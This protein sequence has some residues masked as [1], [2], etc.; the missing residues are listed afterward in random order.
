MPIKMEDI[1]SVENELTRFTAKL[2]AASLWLTNVGTT[3]TKRGKKRIPVPNGGRDTA[4][5]KR[6][7]MDLKIELTKL[8]NPT[9]E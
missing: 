2:E 1:K 8:T 4:A 6:A 9:S 7:A 3:K 5:L